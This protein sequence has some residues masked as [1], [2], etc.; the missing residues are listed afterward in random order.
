MEITQEMIDDAVEI[1]EMIKN[2]AEKYKIL[3]VSAHYSEYSGYVNV[4]E[5]KDPNMEEYRVHEIHR[6]GK[7]VRAYD[8]QKS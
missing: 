8:W 5:Y 7:V 3:L 4:F 1:N 2:F 6:E